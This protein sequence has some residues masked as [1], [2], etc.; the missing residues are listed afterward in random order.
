MPGPQHATMNENSTK[1]VRRAM[2]MLESLPERNVICDLGVCFGFAVELKSFQSDGKNSGP[3]VNMQLSPSAPSVTA[4][5]VNSIS[6][7]VFAHIIGVLDRIF[8]FIDLE[9]VF[10]RGRNVWLNRLNL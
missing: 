9:E 7:H 1:R 5:M 8:L 6:T 3:R 10:E 4:A 2:R